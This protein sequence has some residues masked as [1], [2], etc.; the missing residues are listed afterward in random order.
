MLRYHLVLP[1]LLRSNRPMESIQN[2]T[3][4][5]LQELVRLQADFIVETQLAS[6][7]IPWYRGGITDPWDHV[8]GAIALDLAGRFDRAEA[9]YCWS[10]DKQNPDGSWYS[11]YVDDKPQDLVKDTNFASYIATGMWFHYLASGDMDFLRHMWPMVEGGVDFAVNSQRPT[12]EVPWALDDDGNAWPGAIL[13]SSCCTWHSIR[14]ALRISETLGRGKPEW[15]VA[16]DSLLA[17]INERPD[18]FDNMGENERRYSMNWF[19]PILT[20][21]MKGEEAG[22]HVESEWTDFVI[23]NWGCRVAADEDVTAVAETSE[24]IIALALIGEHV[25]AKLLLDWTLRLRDNE[26]GFCRGVKLPEQE[27]WPQERATWTSAALIMAIA[28]VAKACAGYCNAD[29]GQGAGGDV[30]KAQSPKEVPT[31]F[32]GYE[33]LVDFMRDRALQELEGDLVEIGAFMGGGTAKLAEFAREHGKKVYAV[34]IFDPRRDS[35]PDTSGARMCDIYEAFLQGRSQLEVYREATHGLDNITTID[36]DSRDVRFPE[37]QKFVFGFIDGNHH[38]EYVRNDFHLV[39]GNL[40]PGGA[41]GFHDY[42]FDLPEVTRTIDELVDEHREEIGDVI[43][44]RERHVI[45]LTKKRQ[46]PL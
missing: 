2:E 3:L 40:V 44:I 6:G 26:S 1:P 46:S 8:E 25:K 15:N 19:Y 9:A 37:G 21:V 23:E 16:A 38:P 18:L 11:S 4:D 29:P 22:R 7:A 41:L 45:L 42:N 30:E 14:N 5:T 32:V 31:D 33:V 36:K 17:A 12:G 27:A 28:A 13:T 34:D 35:T 20:G 24:L 43:E 10:R 39:W